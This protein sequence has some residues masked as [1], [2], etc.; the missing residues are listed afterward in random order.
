M[1]ISTKQLAYVSVLAALYIVLA[2]ISI[3]TNGFLAS[4]KTLTVLTGSVTLG[5][6]SGALIALI[7]ETV[8]QLT[9]PYPPDITTPLWILPYVIEGLVA[10]FVVK[11]NLGSV[12]KKQLIW[13]II[14]SEIVLTIVITPVNAISAVIQ[15]WGTWFTVLA[16]VPL[17]F[18]ITAIRIVVYIIVLPL[19]YDQLK[20]ITKK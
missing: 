12:S 15:G 7:G 19:L 1:K 10:G 3:G 14:I 18:G 4:I 5:P 9:G 11:K 13:T 6:W 8:S 2:K 20:K 16:G 17:R